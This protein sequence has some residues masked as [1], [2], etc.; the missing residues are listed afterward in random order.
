MFIIQNIIYYL[1][2][3]LFI[4]IKKY[5]LQKESYENN[6]LTKI[7]LYNIYIEIFIYIFSIY[8]YIYRIYNN[9]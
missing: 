9:I 6:I 1:Y 7:T 2:T 3:S 4:N 5:L 8:K